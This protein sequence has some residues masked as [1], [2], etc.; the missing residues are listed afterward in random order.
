MAL[1]FTMNGCNLYNASKAALRLLVLGLAEEVKSFGIKHCLVEPGFVRTDLLKPGSNFAK[2]TSKTRLSDYAEVNKNV[3][4]AFANF[5]G[6][7]LGDPVKSAEI[8]YDVVTS[9]G[10]AAGRDLPSLLPLGSDA[11]AEIMKNAKATVAGVE[12][13]ADV[14]AQTDY[15]Y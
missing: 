8:I 15:L 9:S 11:V 5:H 1:W 6:T 10:A 14:A 13:W 12:A 4:E 7:Q 2:T 3:D